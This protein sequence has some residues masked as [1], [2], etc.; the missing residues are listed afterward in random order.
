M[1]VFKFIFEYFS[2]SDSRSIFNKNME[3]VPFIYIRK[4]Q[5]TMKPIEMFSLHD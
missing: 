2:L 1:D 5:G 3:Y 4:E